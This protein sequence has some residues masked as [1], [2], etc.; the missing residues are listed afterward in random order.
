MSRKGEWTI[1]PGSIVWDKLTQQNVTILE[2][3]PG[4]SGDPHSYYRIDA[5]ESIHGAWR[6]GFE[7][8]IAK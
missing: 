3:K 6:N 8:G 5:G 1:R 4:E 7:L 2:I